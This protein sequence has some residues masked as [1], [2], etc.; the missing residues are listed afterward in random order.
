MY[1]VLGNKTEVFRTK[2]IPKILGLFWTEKTPLV[3]GNLFRNPARG[4]Q[5]I[6]LR[7]NSEDLVAQTD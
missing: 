3:A 1:H 5:P 4:S 6:D 2:T 7:V